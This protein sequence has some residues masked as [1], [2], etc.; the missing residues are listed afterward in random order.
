MSE[1]RVQD[2]NDEKPSCKLVGVDGNVFS[3][4]GTVTSTL[5]RAGQK[6][7]AKEFQTRALSAESYDA[8]LAMVFEYVTIADV[9]EDDDY[10]G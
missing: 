2:Y 4:I 6:E 3:I 7:Q 5:K 1:E 10:F 9:E 8:V